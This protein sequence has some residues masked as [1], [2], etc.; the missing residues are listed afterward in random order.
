MKR[1]EGI[2]QKYENF[3]E[4]HPVAAT[5]GETAV[6]YA[7][8]YGIQ[9]AGKKL[10]VP[11]GHG[12]SGPGL[13]Q[14]LIEKHPHLA[15]AAATVIAPITEELL[16]RELPARKLEEKGYDKDSTRSKRVKLGMAAAFAVGHAGPHAIPLPQ[17]IGGLHYSRLHEK[18]GL[19]HSI[20][21][22]VTNNTLAALQ[23]GLEKKGRK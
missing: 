19:K 21:A 14:D 9:K 13:R 5:L 20:L 22:H 10:G 6:L 12:R 15:A 2:K 8:R 18:R 1:L 3:A 7:A 23:Y 17:F 16:F 11:L 4:E